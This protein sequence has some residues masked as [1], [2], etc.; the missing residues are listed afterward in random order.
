[1]T[2]GWEEKVLKCD[3]CEVQSSRQV[4]HE[5]QCNCQGSKILDR[6]HSQTN[7]EKHLISPISENPSSSSKFTVLQ[8]FTL[9]SK[10]F[11][12]HS[13]VSHL[14]YTFR[15]IRVEFITLI[16]DAVVTPDSVGTI[17]VHQW[18]CVVSLSTFIDV[19]VIKEDQRNLR[20]N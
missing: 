16:T 9:T 3:K 1:M 7:T 15:F 17:A 6:I 12:K 20:G 13:L 2:V 4:P 19:C 18:T 14:T 8:Y 11:L 5:C 10:S